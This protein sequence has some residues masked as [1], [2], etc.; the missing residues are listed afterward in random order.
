MDRSVTRTMTAL[1]RTA[2]FAILALA[3]QPRVSG[4]SLGGA[5]VCPA[6]SVRTA[7]HHPAHARHAHGRA[8]AQWGALR[9]GAT[10]PASLPAPRRAPSSR[11][12]ARVPA[13]SRVHRSPSG[14]GHRYAVMPSMMVPR[15][16]HAARGVPLERQRSRAVVTPARMP[17]RGPPHAPPTGATP[18]SLPA[19]PLRARP[20]SRPQRPRR[21][22]PRHPRHPRASS[23][24]LT[25]AS[26]RSAVFPGS[27]RPGGHA[28]P[29]VHALHVKE[30][31]P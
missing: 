28:S 15:D 2:I 7:T 10:R 21:T 13:G 19:R 22:P 18:A 1:L 12:A 30:T 23:R 4:A 9:S 16:G 25:P 3:V 17:G 31:R 20:A 6:A 5:Q 11:H 26:S 24:C 29:L 8:A 27:P 14:D